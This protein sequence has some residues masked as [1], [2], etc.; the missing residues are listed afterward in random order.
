MIGVYDEQDR[1]ESY[2]GNEYTYTANGELFK[3]I[4]QE[5][6]TTY[7]Y[8]VFGNL[9]QVDLPDE[10]TIEYVIDGRDRR[11]G[12][13]IDGILVQGFLYQGALNPV[14]EL[15]GDGNLM[16]VFV[17]GSKVNVPDYLVKAG[18]VYR[19]VSD[20]LGSVR[21][22][23]D[24]ADGAVVQRINYDAFGNVLEDTNEGFQPFGFAGGLYDWDIGLVRFGAR[25]YD[26]EVGRWTAVEKYQTHLK[27]FK[28]FEELR[29]SVIE[30][31]RGYMED[32]GKVVC[33][34]RKLREDS[35]LRQGKR[36]VPPLLLPP[37]PLGEGRGEGKNSGGTE[38]LR[39]R[40][41]LRIF[42]IFR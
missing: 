27:Y 16:S 10:R 25:D 24:M 15:G 36:P 13:K 22:V 38:R 32:A 8:D 17:Y 30:T 34:M 5:G 4:T 37:R 6:T 3:K 11:V 20:H 28:T 19:V 35:G 26:S 29:N 2:D 7:D 42:A 1:L 31:F 12:K 39:Y 33:V 18:K 40:V 23:V 41:C 21:L 14:A 9:R